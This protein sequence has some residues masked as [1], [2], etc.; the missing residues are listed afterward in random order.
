[1]ERLLLLFISLPQVLQD[2]IIEYNVE[3]R[4]KMKNVLRELTK[5][6]PYTLKCEGCNIGK[7]GIVLY[8]VIPKNF[9]C[10]RKCL[11]KFVSLLPD[12]YPDKHSYDE[13][14]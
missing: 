10:S 5:Y 12:G 7:I 1:M 11:K 3:H 4:P 8:S 6:K 13:M 14:L 2:L 9:V